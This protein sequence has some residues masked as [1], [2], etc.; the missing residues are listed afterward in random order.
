GIY[1]LEDLGELTGPIIKWMSSKAKMAKVV[2][3]RLGGFF[4]WVE[5]NEVTS[6]LKSAS[7]KAKDISLPESQLPRDGKFLPISSEYITLAGLDDRDY[8]EI[9]G[10]GLIFLQ[11]VIQKHGRCGNLGLF[12]N[13]ENRMLWLCRKH[14]VLM[15]AERDAAATAAGRR[16][17]ELWR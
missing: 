12:V 13:S 16:P 14:E 2:F 10:Q 17:E 11:E 3:P 15:K 9:E 6:F 7:E 4:E 8:R 5:K 1:Y